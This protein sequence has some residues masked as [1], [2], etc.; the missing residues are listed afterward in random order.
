MYYIFKW[1]RPYE[2]CLCIVTYIDLLFWTGSVLLQPW[3]SA[4]HPQPVC[5]AFWLAAPPRSD[6]PPPS[7]CSRWWC[8]KV[9]REQLMVQGAHQGVG[10]SGSARSN[11]GLSWFLT[12]SYTLYVDRISVFLDC[13]CVFPRITNCHDNFFCIYF[14]A[15]PRGVHICLPVLLCMFNQLNLVFYVDNWQIYGQI[16][17]LFKIFLV[18]RHTGVIRTLERGASPPSHC[19]DS[20][21]CRPVTD[22]AWTGKSL[23]RKTPT[24]DP[25]RCIPVTAAAQSLRF[26]QGRQE[27]ALG[28]FLPSLFCSYTE[29]PETFFFCCWCVRGLKADQLVAALDWRRDLT[30]TRV[31]LPPELLSTIWIKVAFLC[32]ISLEPRK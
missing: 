18:F 6:S 10:K 23:A 30:R 29:S 22:W 8:K 14:E 11:P 15:Q 28:L 5:P 20:L 31:L 21:R 26:Q 24:P 3:K 4:T 1:A 9:Q 19:R 12:S 13:L 25:L 32:W 16:K 2:R 17:P 7:V 27:S